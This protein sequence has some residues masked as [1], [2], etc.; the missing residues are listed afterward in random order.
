[1]KFQKD[2]IPT[3]CFLRL[4]NIAFGYSFLLAD[5]SLISSS[6]HKFLNLGSI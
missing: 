4:R 3:S 1:M 5:S 2:D 6:I